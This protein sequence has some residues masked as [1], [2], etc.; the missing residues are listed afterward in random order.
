MVEGITVADLRVDAA[1]GEVHLGQAPGGV[2][3]LMAVDGD[4][5]ELAAVGL[6]ELFAADEHAARAAAGVVDAALVGREHLNQH[7]HHARGRAKLAAA[8]ACGAGEA[9]EKI[10]IDAGQGVLGA[11][12]GMAKGDIADQINDLSKSYLVEAYSPE[13][14]RQ[15]GLEGGVVALDRGHRIV[16]QRANG[17][18]RSVRLEI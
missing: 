18:L 16:D 1:D 4:V 10:F 13:V 7:A 2:V 15:H 8:L 12:G 11:V 17:R 5:A 14:F 3:G 9:G 6:D